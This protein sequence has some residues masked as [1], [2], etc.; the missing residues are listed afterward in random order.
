MGT[1]SN[2]QKRKAQL[3]ETKLSA[4]M[5]INPSERKWLTNFNKKKNK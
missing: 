5:K 4:G 1:L 3:L 2:L